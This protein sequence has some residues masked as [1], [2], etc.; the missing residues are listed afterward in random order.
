[1]IKRKVHNV[2]YVMFLLEMF[3]LNIIARKEAILECEA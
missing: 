1:M 2:I 3:D